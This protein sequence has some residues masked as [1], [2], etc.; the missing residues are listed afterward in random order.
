VR[1]P[2]ALEEVRRATPAGHVKVLFS[3]RMELASFEQR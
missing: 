2:V 1:G 3:E